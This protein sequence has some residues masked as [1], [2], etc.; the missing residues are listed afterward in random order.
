M[1]EVT[2]RLRER[3]ANVWEQAKALAD[4]A[5]DENRA[6]N[7]EEQSSWDTLNA[8]LDALDK[9]IKSVID[10]EQRAK[11]TEEAFTRLEGKPVVPGQ[12]T[13]PDSTDELR[14]FLLGETDKR[15]FDVAPTEPRALSKLTAAAGLNTVPTSFYDRLV[16]HL[17]ET[18]G[19][20]QANPTVLNTQSGETLQIPKTTAHSTSAIVT[21]GSPIGASDPTFG[22][23]SLGA[24][25]Y[26]HLIQVSRELLTDTGVDL[27]GYLAMQSG[28]A[29]GNK[30]GADLVAGGGTTAPWGV[31][32]RATAFAGVTGTAAGFGTQGTAG[33]GG[34][35]FIRLFY[36]V[37]SP[38][39]NSRQA[40]WLMNDATAG[41]VR[42]IKDTTGQYL[43]QP[44]VTAGTPDLLLGKP[45]YTDP[46]VTATFANGAKT[47]VF[48]DFSQYF[49][50]MVGGIRFERS[51]DYAFNTDLV[52]FRAVLRGDGDLVDL[53][54]AIK[55]YSHT[56]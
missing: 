48:G 18:S 34:D 10:G 23:V 38:Y 13:A 22:Q 3:R 31:V 6:F 41:V 51:D 11:D 12:R 9:R 53:T 43:W 40:A 39:R 45:V 35:A 21:E 5:A 25:K 28:R 8:E 1:S 20:L 56:T 29:L 24:F 54:G 36:S 44:S 50:R 15:F 2:T 37:I 17:I 52:T 47:V 55:V 30:L 26:A 33:Q 16:S 32:T 46:N 27:E 4:R 14:K 42:Q 19:V 49:V 7:G